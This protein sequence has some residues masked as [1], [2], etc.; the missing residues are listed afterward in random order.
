MDPGSKRESHHGGVRTH[1]KLE[2]MKTVF[3]TVAFG[4]D[5]I[6]ENTLPQGKAF[7]SH[8]LCGAGENSEAGCKD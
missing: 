6:R 1:I 2:I 8:P 5:L 4:L 7:I 3:L